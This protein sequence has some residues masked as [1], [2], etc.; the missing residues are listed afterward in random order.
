MNRSNALAALALAGF[1]TISVYALQSGNLLIGL[2]VACTAAVAL[3][4]CG[5]L[6]TLTI[7]SDVWSRRPTTH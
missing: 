1:G 5:S 3:T 4:T 2:L 6:V 7:V